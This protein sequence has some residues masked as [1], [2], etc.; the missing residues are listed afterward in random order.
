MFATRLL[1][2]SAAMVVCVGNARADEAPIAKPKSEK[3]LDHLTQG[4]KLYK[5]RDWL[6]AADE[7]KAGALIEESPIFDFNLGQCYRQAGEFEAA[8]W[9]F[10]RFLKAD[11]RPGARTEAVR[12]FIEEMKNAQSAKARASEAPPTTAI[13]PSPTRA[14]PQLKADAE[15]HRTHD[16]ESV[17]PWYHDWFG[18]GIGGAGVVAGGFGIGLLANAASI[19]D[20]ASIEPDQARARLLNE[21]AD[22]RRLIGAVLGIT[23]VALVATGALKL[24]IHD[25]P[26]TS[27][28]ATLL[29][30]P[31]GVALSG[32]F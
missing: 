15:L 27:S 20:D 1:L 14:D 25:S 19:R 5:L 4:N 30:S 24:V 3:A 16:R 21:R 22:D 23:G 26:T 17:E 2:G 6:R 29:F 12:G 18:W 31:T 9:H 11:S 10:T 13:E 7:Y 8:I 32:T 28:T